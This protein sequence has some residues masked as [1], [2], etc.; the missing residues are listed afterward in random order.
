MESDEQR[1]ERGLE[2]RLR[3]P[4]LAKLAASGALAAVVA[5]LQDKR[6][7]KPFEIE[8]L[9]LDSW[10]VGAVASSLAEPDIA[11]TMTNSERRRIAKEIVDSAS[12]LSASLGVFQHKGGMRWPFQPFLDRLALEVQLSEEENLS[13]AGVPMDEDTAHRCR[14]AV[15]HLL[16]H[17]LDMVFEALISGAERFAESD[18]LLKKP[19]DK[20]ADRLYFIRS[21]NRKFC[22]EFRS[23]CRAAVL[24]LT[25]EY[26]DVT[27]L[28]EAAL[29]KLAPFYKPEPIPMSQEEVDFMVHYYEQKGDPTYLDRLRAHREAESKWGMGRESSVE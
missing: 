27:D 8:R 28:D 5:M 7:V 23:P 9:P 12:K 2:M 24:A 22:V 25:S 1:Y 21:L 10:I 26:F 3:D 20:N 11:E 29:S 13:E 19:N 15:Y 4:Q 6:R 16:M 14:F 18:T 17:K